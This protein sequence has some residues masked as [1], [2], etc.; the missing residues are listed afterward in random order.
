MKLIKKFFEV[1]P[2]K[3]IAIIEITVNHPSFGGFIISFVGVCWLLLAIVIAL[4]FKGAQA[5]GFKSAGEKITIEDSPNDSG[6]TFLVT[7]VLPLLTDDIESLR[8]LFV[9]ATMLIMVILLLS[10][11]NTFYQNPV[12]VAMKY[13]SFS[14]KFDNP[15]DDILP[16]NR[17]YIGITK[18]LPL[19]EDKIIKR[20]YIADGVFVI[21]NE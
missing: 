5:A 1:L 7:Y 15:D 17:L 13:R 2:S 11:S 8:G 3:G 18:G 21:F 19:E 20:K 4:G 6:A 16:P 12:L 10:R 9:F 14:F